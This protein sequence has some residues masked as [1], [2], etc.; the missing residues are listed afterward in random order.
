M[1]IRKSSRF[2][3]WKGVEGRGGLGNEYGEV[4]GSV[5]YLS[6]LDFPSLDYL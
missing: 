4:G 3:W 2:R 5:D 1:P 6:T